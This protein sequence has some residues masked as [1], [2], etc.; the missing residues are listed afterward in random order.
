MKRKFNKYSANNN[1]KSIV[2]SSTGSKFLGNPSHNYDVSISEDYIRKIGLKRDDRGHYNDIVKKPAHPTSPTRGRFVGN[3]KEYSSFDMSNNDNPDFNYSMF[4]LIDN[5]DGDMPITY[6]KSIVLPEITVTDNGNYVMDSYNNVRYNMKNKNNKLQNYKCGGKVKLNKYAFGGSGSFDFSKIMNMFGKS[7]SSGS[8]GGSGS[9]GWI[10][11]AKGVMSGISNMANK[12]NETQRTGSLDRSN[13]PQNGTKTEASI[14]ASDMVNNPYAGGISQ[15]RLSSK[16]QIGSTSVGR[17]AEIANGAVGELSKSVGSTSYTDNT[18]IVNGINPGI[19][20]AG[21][22]NLNRH[23]N[24]GAG[25]KSGR[26]AGDYAMIEQNNYGKLGESIGSNWGPLGAGIG[27]LA[28]TVVGAGVGAFDGSRIAKQIQNQNIDRENNQFN[29]IMSDFSQSE[30]NMVNNSNKRMAQKRLMKCGGKFRKFK[31]GG[32]QYDEENHSSQPNALVDH[33]EVLMDSNNNITKAVG[34]SPKQKRGTDQIPVNLND[35]TMILSDSI[36]V[37][38]KSYAKM[39]ANLSKINSKANKTI[40]DPSASIIDK[41]TAELNLKASI[42]AFNKLYSAQEDQKKFNYI[43]SEYSKFKRGG[44]KRY[45]YGGNVDDVTSGNTKPLIGSTFGN[46]YTGEQPQVPYKIGESP[47]IEQDPKQIESTTIEEENPNY[48]GILNGYHGSITPKDVEEYNLMRDDVARKNM[49]VDYINENFKTG[50]EELNNLDRVTEYYINSGTFDPFGYRSK[51]AYNNNKKDWET[52]TNGTSRYENYVGSKRNGESGMSYATPEAKIW[53]VRLA[54]VKLGL[55]PDNLS[56]EDTA[57]IVKYFRDA[58]GSDPATKSD[59]IPTQAPVASENKENL[60]QQPVEPAKTE[61][62]AVD[63]GKVPDVVDQSDETEQEEP[64][65]EYEEP[66]EDNFD[67]IF[68]DDNKDY[69]ED[70]E[71][72]MK[73][74]QAKYNEPI[75]ILNNRKYNISGVM[76]GTYN[77]YVDDS[78]MRKMASTGMELSSRGGGNKSAHSIASSIG[79]SS[80]QEKIARQKQQYDADQIQKANVTNIDVDKYNSAAMK[81]VDDMNMKSYAK[82]EDHGETA[83]RFKSKLAQARKTDQSKLR[84]DRI[85]GLNNLI[86]AQRYMTEDEKRA[87]G[88][89]YSMVLN[90]GP[91]MNGKSFDLNDFMKSGDGVESKGASSV[92]PIKSIKKRSLTMPSKSVKNKT[93]NPTKDTGIKKSNNT[94][95]ANAKEV[96]IN[97]KQSVASTSKTENKSSETNSKPNWFKRVANKGRSQINKTVNKAKRSITQKRDIDPSITNN[98]RYMKSMAN[99]LDSDLMKIKSRK[100]Y[101]KK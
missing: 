72:I 88:K 37:G 77:R 56:Q 99:V 44:C 98:Q 91:G 62:E 87:F 82:R 24:S 69:D 93:E 80:N 6:N 97:H 12:G 84:A 21:R 31:N 101:N 8:A 34:H 94:T 10:G 95:S 45:S 67:D 33:N 15:E 96:N 22:A 7:G 4:G 54:A 92:I 61:E 38:G 40:N 51:F 50:S 27:R 66:E 18:P 75:Q 85:T 25:V 100:K 1:I 70:E 26:L 23:L 17:N 19:E 81:A 68:G 30:S 47:S 73:W 53:A 83:A 90:S 59:A 48:S 14:P 43:G 42:D 5:G 46:R 35:G 29:N 89:A 63:E 49:G 20:K 58:A 2:D 3:D 74:H 9:S 64:P 57:S 65:Y 13:A 79:M 32:M 28:G 76:P 39:A 60:P 52:F 36:G 41:R 55:D 71:A 86:S 16:D 11:L 78:N